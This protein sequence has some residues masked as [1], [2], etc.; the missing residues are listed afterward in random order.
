MTRRTFVAGTVALAGVA[1]AAPGSLEPDGMLKIGGKRTFLLGLYQLPNG[2]DAWQRARAAG[3]HVVNAGSKENLDLAQRHGMYGWTGVGSD[4]VQIRKRVA[5]LKSHPALLYWE[6]EDEPSYQWNKPGPR[7]TPEKIHAAYKLLKEL[8]SVRPVYLNHAP[9]N[10]VETLK[11]YNPGGDLIATDIYAVVPEGIRPQYALWADGKQGDYLDT[12]IS[13]VGR[14]TDKMREVTG[15]ARGLLMV[16]QGFAWE[17]LREKDIDRKMILYPTRQQ[18]RFMAWQAI[19]HG[20]TGLVWWGL[21][22]TPPEASLWNDIVT[23]TTEI[24]Q[25]Q[26]DLSAAAKRSSIP[27][28]YHDTGHSL[29]KG[30]EQAMRGKLFV[31]VNADKN[32]VEVTWQGGPAQGR[33]ERFEPFEV[34]LYR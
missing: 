1:N 34:K 13:Q 5:E 9:T 16:L 4:P 17:N 26:P 23:V 12:T 2:P 27:L 7:V 24:T 8:D 3:F 21:Y 32:M 22:K 29:D 14:Y 10:L 31:A 11:A 20:V 28:K 6:T 18:V 33:R 19:V 30:I 15:P 25:H